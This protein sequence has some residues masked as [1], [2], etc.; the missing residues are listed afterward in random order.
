M[1]PDPACQVNE[2][3]QAVRGTRELVGS[4]SHRQGEFGHL[5]YSRCFFIQLVVNVNQQIIKEPP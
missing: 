1:D 2:T 3:S 4:S 5:L